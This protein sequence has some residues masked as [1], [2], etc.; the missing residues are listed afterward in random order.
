MAEELL[1]NAGVGNNDIPKLTSD[2]DKLGT[3]INDTAT[4]FNTLDKS[5]KAVDNSEESLRSQ[6][7]KGREELA[8][9]TKGT[10]EYAAKLREVADKQAIFNR[11]SREL[12]ASQATVGQTMANI[13]SVVGGLAG[14]FSVA[15]GVMTLFGIENEEAMKSLVKMQ[16]LMSITSGLASLNSALRA[17][18]GLSDIFGNLFKSTKSITDATTVLTT[19]QNVL[20]GSTVALTDAELAK[21]SATMSGVSTTNLST[22]SN[23]LNTASQEAVTLA[24]SKNMLAIME[25]ELIKIEALAEDDIYTSN[26][27]VN[28]RLRAAGV[29]L[30]TISA[31]EYVIALQ[32]EI[33][34]TRELILIKTQA[35]EST[36]ASTAATNANTVATN[37]NSAA[38][39][40]NAFKILKQI[41]TLAIYAAVIYGVVSAISWLIKKLNE[42][43]ADVKIKVGLEEESIKKMATEREKLRKFAI[44][45]TVASRNGDKE[46]VKQL[47]EYAKKEYGVE[48]ERLKSIKTRTGAWKEAF[49]TYLKTAQDTYYNE[50]LS[51]RKTEAEAAL[52]TAEINKQIYGELIKNEVTPI[53]RQNVK[54]LIDEGK[55]TVAF[56]AAQKYKDALELAKQTKKEIEVLNTLTYRNIDSGLGSKKEGGIKEQKNEKTFKIDSKDLPSVQAAKIEVDLLDEIA[57]KRLKLEINNNKQLTYEES[58]YR[59]QLSGIKNKFFNNDYFNESKYLKAINDARILD[60]DNQRKQLEEKQALLKGSANAYKLNETAIQDQVGLINYEIFQRNNYNSILVE[61]KNKRA[62]LQ[63]QLDEI[64]NKEYKT[65]KEKSIAEKEAINLK[66]QINDLDIN[67][68]SVTEKLIKAQDD[69]IKSY[70]EEL[71]KLKAKR[72]TLAKDS[73]EYIDISKEIEDVDTARLQ[74][75][76]DNTQIE[77]ELW[78]K[79]IDK[80]TEYLDAL[81]SLASGFADIS[82]GNMDLINAEYDRQQWN[83]EETVTSEQDKNDQ[84]A[85]LDMER[86]QALQKDFDAQKKW[87]EAQAWMDLASGSVKIWS[88]VNASTGPVGL[89]LSGI[90]QA[91][92]L[93]TTIGNVKSIRAQQMLK[94]HSNNSSAGGGSSGANIALNPSKDSLTSREENLNTMAKSNMKD[95]PQSKVLVSDIN[96]VQ[97]KVKVRESNSTF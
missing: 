77:L 34:K 75:L 71:D 29:N 21:N 78:Q 55:T 1:I 46:R 23:T 65:L 38:V 68:I 35:I 54:K 32:A 4:S 62:E 76:N 91:A 25:Q 69:K 10:A 86:W 20:T 73:Q 93:A 87:K 94:P 33:A 6:I 63:F 47:E 83:I 13:N 42:I 56:G 17:W 95:T 44:D 88:G 22:T 70:N 50:S 67:S 30:E 43:P 52:A 48:A 19:Q 59:N 24:V 3:E 14:G 5:I 12:K 15:T 28:S 72:E 9:M 11:I 31:E 97:T 51:K 53:G 61:S 60:L 40:E 92:L 66:N 36:V 41:R 27:L 82:A 39:N 18:D 58:E 74:A 81:S 64:T 26:I 96:D 45:Y 2:I 49:K 16:A 8:R 89:V 84:L 85:K 80:T 79:K 37:A 90:Q 7:R 57:E